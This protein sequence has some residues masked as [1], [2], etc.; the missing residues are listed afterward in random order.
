MFL[1]L[2]HRMYGLPGLDLPRAGTERLAAPEREAF[3][4]AITYLSDVVAD[5][6]KDE[7]RR[8]FAGFIGASVRQ[9]DN[10]KPRQTRI[11]TIYN[12]AFG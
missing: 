7:I 9:T 10:I 12:R 2:Y 3:K 11:A 6:R 5:G 4:K 1:A 8:G